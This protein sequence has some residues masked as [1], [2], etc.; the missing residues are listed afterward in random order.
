MLFRYAK[1]RRTHN[2]QNASHFNRTS[3]RFRFR[4]KVRPQT[5]EGVLYLMRFI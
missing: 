5:L 3:Y 4:T 2:E 1:I